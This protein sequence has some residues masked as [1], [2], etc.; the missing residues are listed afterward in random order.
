MF[1]EDGDHH[2]LFEY[3]TK[4]LSGVKDQFDAYIRCRLDLEPLKCGRGRPAK[5]AL[6]RLRKRLNQHIRTI[7]MGFGKLV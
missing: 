7:N 6:S 4:D 2:L 1:S 3:I 5:N